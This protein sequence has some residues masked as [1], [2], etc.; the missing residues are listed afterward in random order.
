MPLGAPS[1]PSMPCPPK[2]G[3]SIPA[4][5]ASWLSGWQDDRDQCEPPR[6]DLTARCDHEPDHGGTRRLRTPDHGRTQLGWTRRV[7]WCLLSVKS[8][9]AQIEHMFSA[10]NWIVLQ[11]SSCTDQHKFSGPYARRSRN[12]LRNY[13][14]C[15]ELT[16]DFSNGL[17]A[18]S[19]GDCSSFAPF[20]RN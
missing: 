13:V 5:S 7:A 10:S 11:K 6:A 12:H 8:G 16:A 15:N 17:E 2:I 3:R 19:T 20:A 9:R 18:T 14:I 1:R 4:W